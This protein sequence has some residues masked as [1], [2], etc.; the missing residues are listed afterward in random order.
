MEDT[1]FGFF[2]GIVVVGFLVFIFWAIS[3][4]TTKYYYVTEDGHIGMSYQCSTTD[5]INICDVNN[6]LIIVDYFE[7]N[8][9]ED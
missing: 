3:T 2:M 7:S 1:E 6:K 5:N 8:E 4:T 9:E